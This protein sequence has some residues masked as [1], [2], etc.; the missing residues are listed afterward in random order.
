MF[1]KSVSAFLVIVS[2][3][4][5]THLYAQEEKFGI[6]KEVKEGEEINEKIEGINKGIVVA[7][8]EK[9]VSP[10]QVTREDGKVLINGVVFSPREK[11]PSKQQIKVVVTSIDIQKHELIKDCENSYVEYYNSEGDQK[12]REKI[13]EEY[14]TH[15]LISKI[16]FKDESLLLKFKDGSHI[17]IMMNSFI[18]ESQKIYPTEEEIQV[19]KKEEID[20][21]KSFLQQGWMIVFG[22]EY[23]MY[24]PPK[25]A[26][27]INSIALDV[28]D[29]RLL[30]EKGKEEIVK[31]IRKPKFAEDVLNKVASWK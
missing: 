28:K 6:M 24:I 7:F 27:E 3:L 8:G 13:L 18:I 11:D 26:R 1:K 20:R 21:I 23:T 9:L 19:Q 31:I 25:E 14:D 2:M 12:A 30:P 5:F 22:Y 29:A 4:A 10:Y 17:N 15:P 16:E